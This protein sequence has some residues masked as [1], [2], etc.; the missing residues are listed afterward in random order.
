MDDTTATIA[1]TYRL[2]AD[3]IT[4]TPLPEPSQ[5]LQLGAGLALLGLLWCKRREGLPAE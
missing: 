5:T 3:N 4:P 1:Q 2:R